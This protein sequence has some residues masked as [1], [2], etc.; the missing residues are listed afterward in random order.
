MTQKYRLDF[1]ILRITLTILVI[2][3]H[4]TYYTHATMFGGG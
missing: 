2:M 3:G 1:D 4:A